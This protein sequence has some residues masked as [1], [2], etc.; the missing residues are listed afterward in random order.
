MGKLSANLNNC[1]AARRIER[2][3]TQ[4][5]LAQAANVSR[6]TIIAIEGGA[7]NP[8]VVLVLRLSFLLGVSV[9]DLFSLPDAALK[10]LESNRAQLYQPNEKRG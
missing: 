10:E 2:R 7:Y 4:E 9:N 1:V 8:S 6:Q 5:Q 3:L